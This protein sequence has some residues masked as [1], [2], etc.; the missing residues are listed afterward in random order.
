M[1]LRDQPYIPLYVND[2]MGDE[3]LRECKPQTTGV[4]IM[5]ICLLHKQEEYGKI[6]LNE[7]DKEHMKKD[8]PVIN[9][10]AKKISCHLPYSKNVIKS[11]LKEL[12]GREILRVDGDTLFQKRMVKDGTI[13][14]TRVKAAKS[15]NNDKSNNQN[16]KNND[17]N[18]NTLSDSDNFAIAKTRAKH[19]QNT[20]YENEYVNEYKDLKDLKNNE[21]KRSEETDQDFQKFWQAYPKKV[22]KDQAK[23]AFKKIN[24]SSELLDEMLNSVEKFKKTDGWKKDGGQYI[25]Y[26][27]T[28]LNNKRWEDSVEIP[29]VKNTSDKY[30]DEPPL[31]ELYAKWSNDAIEEEKR[32]F[33]RERQKQAEWEEKKQR[34][35]EEQMQMER[36]EQMRE[37]MGLNYG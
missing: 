24:P 23:K 35:R 37:E 28:W 31:E 2:F 34:E 12:I 22:A 9:L 10:F 19:E 27:A 15:K 16:N 30:A 32:M 1:A 3:K 8:T 14:E 25:P 36:E 11:A 21:E 26:P 18:N 7:F 6:T 29:D 4:Y 33:E 13:S 5:L 17:Q 20:E